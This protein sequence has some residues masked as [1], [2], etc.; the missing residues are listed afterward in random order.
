VDTSENQ[1]SEA[2]RGFVDTA[3]QQWIRKLIDPSRRNNLLYFRQLKKG[4]LDLTGASGDSF[5]AFFAGTSVPVSKLFAEEPERL[6]EVVREIARRA[7]SNFE[8]KGLQTLFVALGIATWQVDDG[9]RAPESPI[10]LLPVSLNP[11]GRASRSF[12][13]ARTGPPQV[14]LVLLHSLSTQFG[15]NVAPDDLLLILNGVDETG[16]F[17]P[18]TLYNQLIKLC[19]NVKGFS[20]RPAAYLGNFAFQK[21]AMVKDLQECGTELAAHDL[22][23][24]IAGDITA[25]S[26]VGAR[27]C[28][29]NPKEL[30]KTPP[31]NEFFVLDA[32]SSQQC[33]VD[34]VLKG[35]NGVIHGPPGTGKSQTIVNLIASM[36]AT[37]KR[38]LFVAEKRA[39]LNVVLDRLKEV[40]L[41]HLAM[42]LH[43]ADISPKR[44][45]AQVG[46][47][48]DIVRA[49]TPVDCAELHSRTVDR[50]NRLNAHV[51]RLHRKCAPAL[52]SVYQLQGRLAHLHRTETFKTRWRQPDL[53]RLDQQ[54]TNRV[55]DLL[56]E[57]EGY[58]SLFLRADLSPWTGVQLRDGAAVQKALDLVTN[59]NDK[60]LP[61][62]LDRLAALSV[63]VGLAQP[64]S[65]FDAIS[66]MQLLADTQVTLTTYS[67]QI[68]A[69]DTTSLA[70]EMERGSKGW[71]SSAWAY[72]TRVSYRSARQAVLDVRI[73]KTNSTGLHSE[74]LLVAE[75]LERWRARQPNPAPKVPTEL[76][77]HKVA[78]DSFCSQLELLQ[79]TL[80]RRLDLL[81]YGELRTLVAALASDLTTPTILPK[82]TSIERELDSHGVSQFVTELRSAKPAL[83]KW[84]DEFDFAWLTSTLDAACGQDPE[85]RGFRG[86]THSGFVDEFVELDEKRIDLAAARVR[87]AHG[88]RAVAAMNAH[89][90]Q[91]LLIRSETQRSRKLLPLRKLFAQ[92]G[93][94]LTAVCPCWMASPLSV[95]QLLDSG[96]RHF[97]VVV[98]DEAS[99]VLPEDAVCAILRG[100]KLVVAGDRNQLPPTTFFA[101]SD[102]DFDSEE[103]IGAAEGFESLLDM[104]NAF[105]PSNY[106]DWHYRSRD[107]S[108]IAFSNHHIYHDRLVTFPGAGGTHAIS[109]V[110]VT[111]QFGVDGEE[112]SC[113]TEV[114]KVIQLVLEHARTRP[115][116]TLG[117]ITMGIKHRDRVQRAL[118]KAVQEHGELDEFFD[119]SKHERYFVKNLESVQGDERDAIIISVGYGKDRAGNLPFRFGP[120]IPE[121][122]RR[123]LNVAVTRARQRLTIV[124]SFSHLDMDLGR[125]RPG[126][127]VE[128]LKNYLEYAASSGKRLGDSTLST[129]APNDFEQDIQD[130]LEARGLRL[131]PQLGSSR[132][133]IDIV[134]EHPR[135]PGRY[136]LAIECD[137]ATYHSSNTAR[138]R[139]RLR[140]R[141]LEALGWRFHRIWSTDWFMRKSEEVERALK[142][143]SE[144]VEWADRVDAAGPSAASGGDHGNGTRTNHNG[145]GS[146]QKAD[147]PNNG[148]CPRP[149][150]LQRASI[151]DYTSDE[152]RR[153]IIWVASD[154]QLRT[155]DEVLREMVEVLGF[156]RRG[157]RI[158][159]RLR[160]VIQQ[161]RKQNI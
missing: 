146:T 55:R 80:D 79:S 85:L 132:Y 154:G 13:L 14:N 93:D 9:G 38:V 119:E 52:M 37:G 102:D 125:V 161:W 61:T 26:A 31:D 6:E 140:Q 5:A 126:S 105:L 106:L 47:S 18:Q 29:L 92:A 88:T 120:L 99:Q 33:A 97:D 11:Q 100:E 23:A 54:S 123:R 156:K 155:D 141:Q 24:A 139:D 103:E 95:S 87:R 45:L 57:A 15:V 117:V 144:A 1:I 94:V 136:V 152:L 27:D 50:R 98:F 3:R 70:K 7:L 43:G 129:V 67:E 115:Q 133:R 53:D 150:V 110:L 127:G 81:D 40:G 96:K 91:E 108:L 149:P 114:Q 22:I 153:L 134:A 72:L 101:T 2:R 83:G 48:L 46:R 128:L 12:S 74:I 69:K 19:R 64:Q 34:A 107:E 56:K 121:G 63:E 58:S 20:I 104:A 138:D 147:R 122:G 60:T 41:D 8:E 130:A 89:P 113:G 78:F 143:F 68:F 16:A 49:S 84:T 51:E 77:A 36:A 75:Q 124:S 35:Q 118:D 10:L 158:E 4:T 148:R 65:T 137:G 90:D 82:L 39:A 151:T 59:L 76:V 66:L 111:Q 25:R 73:G 145:E 160:Q 42:D 142:A 44:V 17:D 109:H 28:E 135:K 116:E 32:D 21:M 71:L 62:I 30:D 86:R 157:P 112:E 159:S 131:I